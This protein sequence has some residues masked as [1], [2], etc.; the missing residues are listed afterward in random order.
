M[1]MYGILPMLLLAA[2]P[3]VA[4]DAG[5]EVLA[6]RGKAEVTHRE[7]DARMAEIPEADRAPF[8]RDAERMQKAVADM[9]LREQLAEEAREAGFDE[10]ALVQERMHLAAQNELAR[11]WLE[12]YIDSQAQPDIEALARE[13]YMLNPHEFMSE[14]QVDVSHILISQEVRSTE[15]A[16]ALAEDVLAQVRAAPESFDEL[17]LQ[18]SDDP[19][20]AQNQGHF[21]GVKRGDMVKPFEDAAFA[22][23][24]GQIDGPVYTVYGYHIMR[25]DA[26]HPPRVL[27]F[28]EVRGRLEKKVL[29]EHR[30]RIRNDYLNQLANQEVHMTTEEV[31]RMLSRYFEPDALA[32]PPEVESE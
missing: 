29:K 14:P 3:A 32:P 12:H 24:P 11:A 30:D 8:L 6:S 13:H 10:S 31:R 27:A 4:D 17:I 20:A 26:A 15:E 28:E 16:K 19:S 21:K 5:D 1:R 18:Y 22:M 9:L 25:L 2:S 7:F 23:E